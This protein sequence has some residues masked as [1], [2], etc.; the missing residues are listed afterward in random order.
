LGR[1]SGRL[2]EFGKS[3]NRHQ[4][5]TYKTTTED[6]SK[7]RKRPLT[8]RQASVRLNKENGAYL[9]FEI[10]TNLR[11]LSG[12]PQTTGKMKPVRAPLAST[13]ANLP[14]KRLG[15]RKASTTREKLSPYYL[16]TPPNSDQAMPHNT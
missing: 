15:T 5:L 3:F 14:S 13:S 4:E 1:L 9:V 11:R 6:E 8:P 2:P 16:P 7:E 10:I 12:N